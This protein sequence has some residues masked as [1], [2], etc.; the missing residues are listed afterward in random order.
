MPHKTTIK[1]V[2]ANEIFR[3]LVTS[4]F[5]VSTPFLFNF[6]IISVKAKKSSSSGFLACWYIS[7]GKKPRSISVSCFPIETFFSLPS[8]PYFLSIGL[9]MS[10]L[11]S[12]VVSLGNIVKQNEWTAMKASGISIYR[13]AIPLVLSGLLLSGFSFLLDNKLVSHGNEKRFDI[14]RDY[15]KRKSRHKIKNT[16]KNLIFQKNLK[17]HISLTKYSVQ[18]EKGYDLT[19]VDLG[20]ELITK[21]IDAKQ[22][23]WKNKEEKWS[24]NNYS[25]R[26]FDQEGR[27]KTG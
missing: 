10:I 11:I 25:I 7:L 13:V 12:T 2:N 27:E 26:F 9:P 16:L 6:F 14:D 20:H 1:F 21:R 4:H 15:V 3:Y 5:I 17:T 23:K 22:I 18:K 24:I 8:L 19:L